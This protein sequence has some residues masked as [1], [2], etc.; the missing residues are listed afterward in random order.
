MDIQSDYEKDME[1]NWAMIGLEKEVEKAKDRQ[2]ARQ[3]LMEFLNQNPLFK[4][5][6]LLCKAVDKY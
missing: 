1:A 2:K 4:T 5:F 6:Y 3:D